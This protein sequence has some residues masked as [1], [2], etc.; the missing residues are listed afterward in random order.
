MLRKIVMH[1]DVE[2]WLIVLFVVVAADYVDE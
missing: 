2:D 1:E